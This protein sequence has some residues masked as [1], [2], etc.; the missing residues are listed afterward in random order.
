MALMIFFVFCVLGCIFL[1]FVLS[2]WTYGD[3]PRRRS[4][5]LDSRTNTEKD[6]SRQLFLVLRKKHAAQARPLGGTPK[7]RQT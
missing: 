6:Q 2:K 1:I 7:A 3:K 5:R 4:R